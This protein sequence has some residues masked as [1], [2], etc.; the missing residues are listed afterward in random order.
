MIEGF[1]SQ[2]LSSNEGTIT[3]D[4][5]RISNIDND[6]IYV[7]ASLT[8]TD[9]IR[10][11]AEFT[12][13]HFEYGLEDCYAYNYDMQNYTCELIHSIGQLD[14]I[15]SFQTRWMTGFKYKS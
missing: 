11:C 14:Y 4:Y 1:I 3:S 8:I 6:Q 15:V 9:C 13:Q 7:S 10:K 5:G 12:S 2:S